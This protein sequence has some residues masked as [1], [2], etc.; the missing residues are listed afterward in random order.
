ML[1]YGFSHGGDSSMI[2]HVKT[3][4][5][6]WGVL[7]AL[8]MTLLCGCGSRAR[9]PEIGSKEYIEAVST[10]YVGLA[11]LQVGGSGP[12][13]GKLSQLEALIPRR[14]AAWVDLGILALRQ[15]NFDA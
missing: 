8:M 12:S 7:C 3:R 2:D 11:A 10:F 4:A 9:L 1:L 13:R 5:V 6:S 15:R 14:A